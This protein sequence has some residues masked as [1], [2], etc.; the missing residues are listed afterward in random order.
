MSEQ[1]FELVK[2]VAGN[3]ALGV[4][5]LLGWFGAKLADRTWCR[6]RHGRRHPHH[7]PHGPDMVQE[8]LRWKP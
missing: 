6:I 8:L 4:G 1:E 2:I 7:G 3:A 5:A